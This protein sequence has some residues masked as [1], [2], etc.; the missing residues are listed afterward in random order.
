VFAYLDDVERHGEWQSR[1]SLSSR[2]ATSRWSASAYA[3][4]DACPAATLDDV[5]DHE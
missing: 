3:K 1:S 2:R 5:R 4:R